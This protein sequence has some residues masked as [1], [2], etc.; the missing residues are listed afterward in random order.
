M[1]P[2]STLLPTA[3]LAG[4]DHQI[5]RR[6]N[7]GLLIPHVEAAESTAPLDVVDRPGPAP[8]REEP[9]PAPRPPAT[10]GP[11]NQPL[12]ESPA[13]GPDPAAD[14]PA[15]SPTPTPAPV[16]VPVPIPE[17]EAGVAGPVE[18]GRQTAPE[19][20]GPG[21]EGIRALLGRV[22]RRAARRRLDPEDGDADVEPTPI[23]IIIATGVFAVAAT[24]S[25]FVLSFTMLL[26]V[27]EAMGWPPPIAP[28]GAVAID[29]AALAAAT[30]LVTKDGE[31]RRIGWFLL[32]L[33]TGASIY[34][35]L[36]GHEIAAA[37]E[38]TTAVPEDMGPVGIFF[39]VF[40][41]AAMAVLVHCLM[42]QIAT[43]IAW[44][45]RQ[46]E[47]AAER[48]RR[49]QVEREAAAAAERDRKERAE[50][51]AAQREE[52]LGSL[53]KPDKKGDKASREVGVAYGIAHEV[54]T[55]SRLKEVLAKAWWSPASDTAVK[56]WCAEVKR[57]LG[58]S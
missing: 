25:A 17:L 50:R 32:A 29:V 54:Y 44:S 6:T 56:Q 40:F 14:E 51:A 18:A 13:P 4:G 33:A 49:E 48:E 41:P 55:P 34:G 35:N 57:E 20:A 42:S 27:M 46:R 16:P 52:L 9:V 38:H 53:P 11:D 19:P 2:N 28:F 12:V 45:K 47:L 8:V 58:V 36:V 10:D 31:L 23:P 37:K 26:L 24:A 3:G 1:G 39:S 21:E 22:L 5:T 15:P 7:S 43:R 30:F